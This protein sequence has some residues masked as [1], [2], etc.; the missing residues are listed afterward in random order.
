MDKDGT[1]VSKPPLLDGTNYD[2]WKSR[3]AAFLKSIDSRTWKAVLRGWE[4]PKV[5][6]ANG[7]DTEELKPEEDWTPA[8]DTLALGNNKA[9]N[10]LFNGVDK[11]MF[12]LIKQCTVA[13]DAWEILKTTHEGT[14]KV[15]SSRLQLLYT[16]FE[17]LRMKEEETIYDF[18]M[19]VL[20]LANSFDSL[21]ERL[22]DEKLV[23]KI[24]RSL[25]KRFNMKVTAIEEA[26]DIASMKVE[27]VVG[28]LQTFE[29]NFSDKI[30]K[31][32]K[33]IAFISN[34]D[35]EE[36]DEEDLSKDIV[37]LGRQFNKI[38]KSVDR[39]PRRNVQH[40]QP[41]ISK[42]GNTSAK[43]E[44]DDESVQ[45]YECEGYGHIK[46]ECATYLKKQKKGL[47]VTWYDEDISDNEL[48]G[49]AANHV[50]A[51]TGVCDS[52]N[53]SC[54]E[55]LT[56]KELASAYKELCIR[57]EKICRT[58]VEQEIVINQLKSEKSTAV[59]Q[60]AIIDQL[61]MEEQKLQA[62]VTNLED[63]VKQVTS[64][65]EIMTKSVRMLGTGT[66][67]LNEILSIRN[68]TNDP[69]V[70]GC[71]VIYNN[72]TLK[73]NFVPAQN[74]YDLKMLPHPAPHQ[75]LVNK[76]KST[77]LKCHYCGKYG[78][79]KS[80]CYKLYGYRK[81]KPQPRA[82]HRMARTKK[83]WKPKAKVAAHIAHTAFRASSKEDW[84]FDSGCSRHMTGEE[85][86][87]VDIKSYTSSYVTF[88]DGVKGQIMGVG[89]LTNNGLPK[90]DN[91]LLVKGLRANLISISQLSDQG[92][93]VDFSKNECLVTN[94]KGELLMKGA[95]SEDNCY[96]WVPQETTQSTTCLISQEDEAR[97]WHQS[98]EHLSLEGM[99]NLVPKEDIRRPPKL[100]IEEG[101]IC[102]EDQ[103]NK[104]IQKSY[105]IFQQQVTSKVHDVEP[106][107]V[108]SVFQPEDSRLIG[109]CDA[110]LEGSADDRNSTSAGSSC[111]QLLW[112]KQMLSE[113][114]VEQDVLTL[115]CDNMSAI[116]ISKNPIQHSS[117]K[118][119][120]I[121]HHFIRDLVED[122]V[123][124]L[125]HV[126]TNNQ[127][128][129]IFTK[130]LDAS[131]FETLRGKLCICL[132]DDQ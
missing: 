96:L 123:V 73:S 51:M 61:K 28:S 106:Y 42:Q 74:R 124:T 117:T 112:M 94:D 36:V 5:K 17:N 131:K 83:E 76:R 24:L 52:D 29:M 16:K 46:T 31:K 77:S 1:L 2:Y 37:L 45:C 62:K 130:A 109:Y 63:E 3:M 33:S 84:Y 69:T 92:L 6:D 119:I 43:T 120:D 47:A 66:K 4:H 25:P 87:L 60:R 71:E 121:R 53:D 114:N 95:R 99:K 44:T 35:N 14:S 26:Q 20:D 57:S 7:I 48:E 107:M 11:N 113:Y 12:R 8:E 103:I 80:F 56:Y 122:K 81:K 79:I 22:S 68:H 75:K 110:D 50:S 59:E 21:G 118:H 34:T 38:L 39:R 78:H 93:K 98:Y 129:D 64:N 49:V 67:K 30:E 97:L 125:E 128:A 100:I 105:P 116:N 55:D 85:R 82:Y 88:G 19:N 40:I 13:K 108:T 104:Q 127:L 101:D 91:V 89:K 23:R 102:G 72:E 10:A 9:L 70:V 32:G 15:K 115:Y 126:A 54:D 41:D 18:H 132:L 90:L 58:N 86:F 111:S 65:L 27:E